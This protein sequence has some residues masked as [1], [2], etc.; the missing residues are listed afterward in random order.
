[1][2]LNIRKEFLKL[3]QDETC[4]TCPHKDTPCSAVSTVIVSTAEYEDIDIFFFGQGAGKDEDININRGNTDKEPFVG[5][6][7]KYLRNMLK[8]I[9]ENTDHRFNIALSNNVRCHPVDNYGK[10]RAPTF[11]EIGRCSHYLFNDLVLLRPKCIVPVGKSAATTLFPEF[12]DNTMGSI[13]A[14]KRKVTVHNE[15]GDALETQ[16]VITY[17]PSY[18]CRNYG[19][20]N[21]SQKN[22]GDVRFIADLELALGHSLF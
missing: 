10:D 19:A 4:S 5:R 11:D 12:A 6:A 20:F 16:S 17:H 3:R 13:R 22:Q 18:L 21:F 7:G 15:H 2:E 1:M 9:W 14:R 8:Y